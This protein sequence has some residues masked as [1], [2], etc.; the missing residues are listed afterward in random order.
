MR[1][2]I[3]EIRVRVKGVKLTHRKWIKFVQISGELTGVDYYKMY[4]KIQ[5]KLDLVRDGEELDKS[6]VLL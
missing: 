2:K 4:Y 6:G 3:W 5:E 1:D